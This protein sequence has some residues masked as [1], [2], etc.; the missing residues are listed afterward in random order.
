MVSPTRAAQCIIFIRDF[1]SKGQEVSGYIDF[2]HRLAVENFELYFEGKKRLM[3][4]PS[5]LS[6]YNWETQTS[7]SNSSPN[8]QVQYFARCVATLLRSRV[9]SDAGCM[10]CGVTGC[11]MRALS[12]RLSLTT[13]RA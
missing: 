2:A 7:T 11:C 9:T 5:D 8:F 3:P 10:S 1:T 12:R 4:K 6:Y 13:R